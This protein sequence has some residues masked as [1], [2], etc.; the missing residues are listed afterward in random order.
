M[1]TENGMKVE[2]VLNIEALPHGK[3]FLTIINDSKEKEQLKHKTISAEIT[4][5]I[6][7][8]D[9]GEIVITHGFLNSV[10]RR[11]TFD[12]C[13]N[14]SFIINTKNSKKNRRFYQS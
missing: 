9:N 14:S 8:E 13:A 6:E 3:G 12:S 10:R 2:L 5:I 4:M 1:L 11:F 7:K